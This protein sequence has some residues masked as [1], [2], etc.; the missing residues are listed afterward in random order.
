MDVVELGGIRLHLLYA[1]PG[2]PGEADNVL[3]GLGR[4]GPAVILAD[5]DTDDALRLKASLAAKR[6]YEPGFV[7]ALFA[8]E[9]R[10]R[11]GGNA[12]P[13][14]HPIAAAAR[15]A[16]D[17]HAELVPLRPLGAKPGFFARRRARKA[18]GTL[19]VKDPAVFPDEFERTMRDAKVWDLDAEAMRKRMVRA[20]QD[21]RAPVIAVLQAHRRAAFEDVVLT[22]RRIAA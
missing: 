18:I 20:L 15:Y 12:K 1:Y 16:R 17:R 13:G 5:L 2:L 7:D 9:A 3:R 6:P 4:L 22:T 8:E 19:D 10:R 11:Y 14:E 21:G